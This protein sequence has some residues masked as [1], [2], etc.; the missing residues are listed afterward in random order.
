M[1]VSSM[2]INLLQ[3]RTIGHCDEDVD[4]VRE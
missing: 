4:L 2:D 3:N 1:I